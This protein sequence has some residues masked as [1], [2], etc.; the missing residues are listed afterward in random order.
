MKMLNY[1]K[2]CLNGKTIKFKQRIFQKHTFNKS[3]FTFIFSIVLLSSLFSCKDYLSI[4][5]YFSDEIKLDS[6]FANTR[7]IKAYMWGAANMFPD[8]GNLLNQN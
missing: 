7:Y 8:E 6:V 5:S 3:L 2:Q 4:D 1:Y